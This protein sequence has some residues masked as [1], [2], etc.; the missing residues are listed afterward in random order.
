MDAALQR[1]LARLLFAIERMRMHNPALCHTIAPPLTGK[2]ARAILVV[3]TYP[4]VADAAVLFPAGCRV[5]FWIRTAYNSISSMAARALLR[6]LRD[7]RVKLFPFRRVD[8]VVLGD[9]LQPVQPPE[10]LFQS[11]SRRATQ[12]TIV[13]GPAESPCSSQPIGQALRQYSMGRLRRMVPRP[14]Y[15]RISAGCSGASSRVH[16]GRS[17]L[18]RRVQQ[19][20]PVSRFGY[21]ACRRAWV[22]NSHCIPRPSSG[23]GYMRYPGKTASRLS[24]SRSTATSPYAISSC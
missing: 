1:R 17:C 7:N 15:A 3:E 12:E 11:G 24:P 13:H 14:A 23:T 22:R 18:R 5:L 6:I 21:P 20:P 2:A 16:A 8:A 19:L 4:F 10:R 9:L